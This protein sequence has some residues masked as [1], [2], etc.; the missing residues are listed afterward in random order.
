MIADTQSLGGH[1]TEVQEC[2]IKSHCGGGGQLHFFGRFR[3]VSYQSD[4]AIVHVGGLVII[5]FTSPSKL[6]A[7]PAPL[8][9]P[10][11]LSEASHVFFSMFFH[12]IALLEHVRRSVISG[13]LAGHTFEK[14]K[15]NKQ[16]R[17]RVHGH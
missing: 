6:P 13:S 8:V 7:L 9:L 5:T 3:P 16:Q 4:S 15:K 10:V 1:V 2:Y 17:A 11:C 14:Q 12:Y